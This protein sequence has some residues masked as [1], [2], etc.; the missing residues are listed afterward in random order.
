MFNLMFFFH[1]FNFQLRMKTDAYWAVSPTLSTS[2]GLALSSGSGGC[3]TSSATH[4]V[5]LCN[6]SRTEN[7]ICSVQRA[8]MLLLMCNDYEGSGELELLFF[9]LCLLW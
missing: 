5:M 1:V 2:S 4:I 3:S 7:M 6:L 9:P 8:L